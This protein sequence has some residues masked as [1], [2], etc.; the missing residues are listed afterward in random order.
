MTINVHIYTVISLF[1]NQQ[2][3]YLSFRSVLTISTISTTVSKIKHDSS[4]FFFQIY[5][6]DKKEVTHH[7]ANS[8]S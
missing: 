8:K 1:P 4:H 3:I 5:L 7:S 2:Y 6:D